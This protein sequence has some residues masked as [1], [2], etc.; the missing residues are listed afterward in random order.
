MHPFYFIP[1][2][3]GIENSGMAAICRMLGKLER[4]SHNFVISKPLQF[5]CNTNESM[6]LKTAP[7]IRNVIVDNEMY[8]ISRFYLFS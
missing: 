8:L 4:I 1:E 6:F 7:K 3:R 2:S 5:V